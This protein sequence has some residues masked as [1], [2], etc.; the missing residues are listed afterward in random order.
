MKQLEVVWTRTASK[1]LADIVEQ[2]YVLSGRRGTA[3]RYGEN[4][5][6]TAER[7]GSALE[8]GRVRD[9]LAPGLR[10][11]VFERRLPILYRLVEGRVRISRV[12]DGRR[13]YARLFDTF[14]IR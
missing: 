1:E 9:D 4:V 10:M 2:I 14:D 5:L 13:D 3:D 8:G 7:I 12:L 11:W 6:A